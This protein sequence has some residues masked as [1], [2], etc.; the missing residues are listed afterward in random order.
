[1]ETTCEEFLQ[2]T[3]HNRVSAS[4]EINIQPVLRWPT[5]NVIE[6]YISTMTYSHMFDIK[7]IEKMNYIH[8]I[9]KKFFC[10]SLIPV[11]H[12]VSGIGVPELIIEHK[13]LRLSRIS[14]MRNDPEEGE[15][16]IRIFRDCLSELRDENSITAEDCKLLEPKSAVCSTTTM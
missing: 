15:Y 13:Q 4:S 16:V 3:D 7:F 8:E 6:A 12:Y 5:Q 2:V 14:D 10:N 1:M 9:D 11:L